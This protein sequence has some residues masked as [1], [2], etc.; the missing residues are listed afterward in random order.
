MSELPA[1]L[2]D[3][4]ER[5]TRY[6]DSHTETFFNELKLFIEEEKRRR[7]LKNNRPGELFLFYNGDEIVVTKEFGKVEIN[8]ENF[9]GIPGLIDQLNAD[10]IYQV[11][12]LPKEFV[13]M[14]KYKRVGK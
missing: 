10:G 7:T 5:V 3:L 6:N 9:T 8:K 12:D 14:G 1:S 2:D 13:I 4:H 11:E